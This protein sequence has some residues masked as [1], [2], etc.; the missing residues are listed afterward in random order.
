MQIF[1]QVIESGNFTR[2]AQALGLPRSTIS[3]TVQA[4]EDRLGVQLL[5]RTTRVVRA[6]QEGLQFAESARDLIDAVAAAEGQFR[7]QH[8]DIS[9]RLRIDMPSRMARRNVIPH[10]HD[11]HARYPLID[12]D[13]SATDRMI[14]LIADG[15]DAVVRLAEPQDSELICRKI[16]DVPILTCAGKTYIARHGMP[17]TPAD[18]GADLGKH[19]LVNYA[20]RRP[21]PAATWEGLDAGR[22]IRVPMRSYLCVDNAESYVAGALHD[23]GLIQVPAHD[24][25]GDIAAGDLIEVLARYRPAPIPVSIL[26]ARRRHLAPRLKVF[27]DWLTQLLRDQGF[28]RPS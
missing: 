6:T 23:H 17:A 9:G 25:A 13:I 19:L 8:E 12:L 4:L 14:D 1:T 2:A 11:F 20:P 7:H 22:V 24:V 5:Q 28:V 18:L 21:A 16:G 27:M 15:V 10:L 3:T 26:F